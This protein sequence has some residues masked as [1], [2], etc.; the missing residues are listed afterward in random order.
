MENKGLK[1]GYYIYTHKDI[2]YYESYFT[3][4]NNVLRS[5]E[6]DKFKK[7]E[8]TDD[9]YVFEIKGEIAVAEAL[10]TN[11]L[12]DKID[13]EYKDNS[14]WYKVL[15]HSSLAKYYVD[16]ETELPDKIVVN[17]RY[18]LE[19]EKFEPTERTV[20]ISETYDFNSI[21]ELKKIQL[22][23]GVSL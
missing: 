22:P 11:L 5:L 8:E 4:I 9:T 7:V 6:Y 20:E 21:N 2:E 15:D 1:V 23:Q 19:S 3:E 18:E 17:Y 16:K 13:E 12:T 14:L 10:S